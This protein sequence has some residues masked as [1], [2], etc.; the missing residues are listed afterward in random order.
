[1]NRRQTELSVA[2]EHFS[3]TLKALR[4]VLPDRQ[5]GERLRRLSADARL[6]QQ[7][8]VPLEILDSLI[9][10]LTLATG[11]PALLTQAFDTLDYSPEL[12]SKTY[13]A[14]GLTRADALVLLCRYCRINSEGMSLT[15]SR[16][17]QWFTLH[18]TTDSQL[19]SAASQHAAFFHGLMRTLVALGILDSAVLPD[20]PAAGLTAAEPA[21]SVHAGA[22][23]SLIHLPAARLTAPLAWQ[24][25]PVERL[26]RRERYLLRDAVA[27]EWSC[28]VTLLLP[29]LYRQGQGD[30]DQCASLL[31]VSRRT[32]QRHIKATGVTFRDLVEDTR[33]SLAHTY[34]A[35]S[36]SV[37]D[38]AER[39]GYR[40]SA[41]FYRVF[42]HWYACSPGEYQSLLYPER[43]EPI[44][45]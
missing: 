3:T 30:I 36:C 24:P 39:L 31:A 29:L 32:L 5:V 38:V 21:S 45:S 4:N 35:Q 44:A 12:L 11:A 2:S 43:I 42:R 17:P 28:A 15:L 20:M 22:C 37:D 14:G 13:L 40:Q 8:R 25:C 33:K 34:L 6:L 27:A 23:S 16:G 19:A 41:Q 18:L 7:R 26:A 10:E 9:S 1:M